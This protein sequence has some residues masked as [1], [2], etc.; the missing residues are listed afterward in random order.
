MMS[1]SAE[2]NALISSYPAML[3]VLYL[4]HQ[5]NHWTCSG[6]QFYGNHL[7]FERLYREAG[8]D[9]D[10]AAEKMIGLFGNDSLNLVKQGQLIGK[11]I[12]RYSKKKDYLEISLAGE[13]DFCRFSKIFIEKLKSEDKLTLG[14]DDLI[15]SL[16]SR[17]EGRVYLLKQALGGR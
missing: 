4:L 1:I 7:L 13:E 12:D 14:L 16:A 10:A 11:M 9:S 17:A 15:M 2:L 5:N 8:E 3:R 6:Q